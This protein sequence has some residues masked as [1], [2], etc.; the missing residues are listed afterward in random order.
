M[1]CDAPLINTTFKTHF[2]RYQQERYQTTAKLVLKIVCKFFLKAPTK[3]NFQV[4]KYSL[5]TEY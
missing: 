3:T 4:Q 1:I 5:I 2:M